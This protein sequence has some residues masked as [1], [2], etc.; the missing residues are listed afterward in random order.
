MGMKCRMNDNDEAKM[1]NVLENFI[2]GLRSL[3]VQKL[4]VVL[5]MRSDR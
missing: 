2:I 4:P 3:I 1:R 5:R